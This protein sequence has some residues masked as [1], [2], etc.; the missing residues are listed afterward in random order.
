MRPRLLV[1]I[2]AYN[3]EKT[4]QPTLQRIPA[5]L[6]DEFDVEVLVIDD[7]ST[8]RTFDR[9]EDLRRE[10]TFPFALTVLFNPVNQG[11]GGNQKIGF[12]YAIEHGFDFVALIHGDG[13]YAPECLPELIGPPGPC[14]SGA[15]AARTPA[16]GI[17]RT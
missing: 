17:P 13:Q 9:G 10:P 15:A 8:D 1:F 5:R 14:A 2:V 4:I 6:L 3:A 16:R 7:S 12:H 11:Y